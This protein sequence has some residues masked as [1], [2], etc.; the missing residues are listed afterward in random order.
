MALSQQ[1]PPLTFI[2]E[3]VLL[4]FQHKLTSYNSS[5]LTILRAFVAMFTGTRQ[6][7]QS[8]ELLKHTFFSHQRITSTRWSPTSHL[9]NVNVCLYDIT[10]PFERMNHT[11][12][13]MIFQASHQ[14]LQH[15]LKRKFLFPST[16]IIN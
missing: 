11:W 16:T 2:Q 8:L 3:I 5:K 12:S 9:K 4:L 15:P 14:G 6:T 13:G 7:F 10:F 1:S